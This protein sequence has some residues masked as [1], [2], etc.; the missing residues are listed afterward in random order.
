VAAAYGPSRVLGYYHGVF[1]LQLN[2]DVG[3]WAASDAMLLVYASGFVLVPI[4]LAG[5]AAA[6]LRP[7]SK[8]EHAFAVLIGVTAVLLLIEAA[9]YAGNGPGRFHERYLIAIPTF[10]PLLFCLACARDGQVR[11]RRL[12]ATTF[13]LGLVVVAARV[14]L[15]G[16]AAQDGSQDSPMLQAVNA[17][18]QLLGTGT[19]SLV[20]A[21]GVAGLAI[22]AVL[23]FFR[24]RIGVPLALGLSL[25][26]LAVSSAGAITTDARQMRELVSNL[27]ADMSLVDHSGLHDVPVLVTPASLPPLVS[28]HL[29]WNQSL[30]RLLQMRAGPDLVDNFG[31]N[32]A[33]VGR[34][35]TILVRGRPIRGPVLVEEYADVATLAGARLLKTDTGVSLW[36]TVGPA[37]LE[38]LT[39]GRY[40]DG[41][42]AWPRA[43]VTVWPHRASPRRGVLCLGFSLPTGVTSEV[44]LHAPGVS[45]RIELGS[46][47]RRVVALPV[48]AKHHFWKLEIGSTHPLTSGSRLLSVQVSRPR[49]IAGKASAA[50]CR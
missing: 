45:R 2:G 37:R 44:Q 27:P 19:G 41:W 15:S 39:Y 28:A 10:V 50:T 4:A 29:F 6:L 26:V 33:K 21:L 17:L 35:G 25:A 8:V 9:L 36:T 30:T 38:T 42:L 18:E 40:L 20:I 48:V 7:Q 47:E 3:R 46:G 14:P 31:Y 43:T 13:S 32:A 24:A 23:P 1:D 11:S 22:P 16:Y 5:L 49:F 34:D 12:L